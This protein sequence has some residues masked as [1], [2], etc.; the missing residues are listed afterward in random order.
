MLL[1]NSVGLSEEE[2]FFSFASS[3]SVKADS[4]KPTARSGLGLGPANGLLFVQSALTSSVRCSSSWRPQKKRSSGDGTRSGVI[5]R[6][7]RYSLRVRSR[8]QTNKNFYSGNCVYSGSSNR[9]S[10]IFAHNSLLAADTNMSPST[11]F[12]TIPCLPSF[13]SK[14]GV[15]AFGTSPFFDCAV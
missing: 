1:V 2:W 8:C 10:S 4:A 12:M 6:E 13:F 3:S 11:S 7:T 14:A 15:S 9:L 5:S